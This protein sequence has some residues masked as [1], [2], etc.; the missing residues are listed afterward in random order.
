MLKVSCSNG[1]RLNVP[2]QHAGKK[3]KCPKCG[4]VVRLPELEP[5][6]E[7][8][9]AAEDDWDLFSSE[10]TDP[11]PG[12]EEDDGFSHDGDE[13]ASALPPRSKSV[14]RAS[15]KQIDA[16]EVA[17]GASL[18]K[19]K[20]SIIAAGSV[21]GLLVLGLVVWMILN[22]GSEETA[23]TQPN[24]VAGPSSVSPQVSPV[25][26]PES[27][28]PEMPVAQPS[29]Q[30]PNSVATANVAP[31]VNA[32]EPVPAVD[33]AK[34]DTAATTA[35]AKDTRSE[36][37]TPGRKATAGI[38]SNIREPET[39]NLVFDERF[40]LKFKVAPIKLEF[41]YV[42]A[43]E[44]PPTAPTA[45]TTVDDKLMEIDD[46]VGTFSLRA[47]MMENQ[48]VLFL[49]PEKAAA[50]RARAVP[51]PIR[52]GSE[53]MQVIAVDQYKG[54]FE[55]K[56]DSPIAHSV[57]EKLVVLKM[58]AENLPINQGRP[59]LQNEV[60]MHWFPPSK[61]AG[62]G[63]IFVRYID[64]REKKPAGF[65]WRVLIANGPTIARLNRQQRAT[66]DDGLKPL[67]APIWKYAEAPI[68]PL[69]PSET[70]AIK[71]A[72]IEI[73]ELAAKLR[74]SHAGFGVRF[75]QSAEER[76]LLFQTIGSAPQKNESIVI[77]PGA[78]VQIPELE[79]RNANAE[80][81]SL[82]TETI[83]LEG[84]P[85]VSSDEQGR[86]RSQVITGVIDLADL[87]NESE[88][89]GHFLGRKWRPKILSAENG[90]IVFTVGFND[91]LTRINLD[92]LKQE[93]RVQL[94]STCEAICL[95]SEGL[96]VLCR[97]PDSPNEFLSYDSGWIKL[98]I[99]GWRLVDIAEKSGRGGS[100][101][102]LYLLNP[103]TLEVRKSYHFRGL[104][105]AGHVNLPTIYVGD[106]IQIS[107][108]NMASATLTDVIPVR[109]NSPPTSSLPGA[110]QNSKD[111]ALP[112]DYQL[113]CDA[114]GATLLAIGTNHGIVDR[115]AAGIYR[116][117]I[118]NGT[119]ELQDSLKGMAFED[120][121]WCVS[122]DGN[123]LSF[124]VKPTRES[125][126]T[127]TDSFSQMMP[128]VVSTMPLGIV[129]AMDPDSK[130]YL[131]VFNRSGV[132]P[133]YTLWLSQGRKTFE[134]EIFGAPPSDLSSLGQG[135]FLLTTESKTHLVQ[136]NAK[137]EFWPFEASLA[138]EVPELPV[139][140]K[141]TIPEAPLKPSSNLRKGRI[142][143]D[144]PGLEF[145]TWS[146]SGDAYFLTYLK[147]TVEP[148]VWDSVIYRM[149]AKSNTETHQW[150]FPAGGGF[151]FG[152][153]SAS[154]LL[155]W[156]RDTYDFLLLSFNDLS[157]LWRI[158]CHRHGYISASPHH[159]ILVGSK[160]GYD[161]MVIDAETRSVIARDG[162]LNQ[163]IPELPWHSFNVRASDDPDVI[164]LESKEEAREVKV[165][166]GRLE[167]VSE[168]VI[169]KADVERLR[170]PGFTPEG[171]RFE[172][173]S[174]SIVM[175]SPEGTRKR[176]DL[177][178]NASQI[179]PHPIFRNR[180]AM[181]SDEVNKDRE[182][183]IEEFTP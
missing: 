75:E 89:T 2:A 134:V 40:I 163:R 162:F 173:D 57:S 68:P 28:A 47:S 132:L 158:D 6:P 62:G 165:S 54:M 88:R 58:G 71:F 104:C 150:T 152:Q 110:E 85:L 7:L 180:I 94:P 159:S 174:G 67:T 26:E 64:P 143:F 106:E 82:Q 92:T 73:A 105:V 11:D 79:N 55:L 181:M 13:V 81:L 84:E 46:V 31:I 136:V 140:G 141:V 153:V 87:E 66:E 3:V 125:F 36:E 144:L 113:S 175:V 24:D 63:T 131:A 9:I 52:V 74:R 43:G 130:A 120:T 108:I 51:F 99:P 38:P 49:D 121:P 179:W 22:S 86:L 155:V 148:T 168:K 45:W 39:H 111:I 78:G 1:H 154:G 56:R 17:P 18:G 12:S 139:P 33:G 98:N 126:I 147:A 10:T 123:L 72:N 16:P 114:D 44:P 170:R 135:R 34:S 93:S 35:T 161:I 157:Q 77:P 103:E 48:N 97:T 102:R 166:N 76:R 112:G 50:F 65:G 91:K 69:P 100:S 83:A 23:S 21:A 156:D 96:V 142:E 32:A 80:V 118:G 70:A 146:P 169:P 145:L 119:A 29:Q 182:V 101:S 176:M 41:A 128:N 30:V 167:L 149:D 164:L 129:R 37:G 60:E 42:K 115:L 138:L 59:F 27:S 183:V 137:A 133:G 14:N 19:R 171:Y 61:L 25:P 107:V 20:T 109:Q 172:L 53:A 5:E 8:E 117:R 90:R 127:S 122:P 160:D 177:L 116:F 151:S 178:D 95:C 15:R 4:D 124:Q